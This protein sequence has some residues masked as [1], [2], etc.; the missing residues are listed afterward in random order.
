[1]VIGVNALAAYLGPS[2]LQVQRITD[3]FVKPIAAQVGLFGPVIST[4]AILLMNWLA[5][6][7]M[8]RRKIFLRP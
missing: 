1:V 3:P 2:I 7:W 8:Y 5:L 6:F 4:G